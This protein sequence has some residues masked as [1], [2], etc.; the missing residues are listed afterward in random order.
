MVLG[1]TALTAQ[2]G[3]GRGPRP[4]AAGPAGNP[5]AADE[6]ARIEELVN[7]RVD[8]MKGQLSLTDKQVKDLTTVYT[9]YFNKQEKARIKHRESQ[10]KNFESK[11][12]SLAKILTPEQMQK[13]QDMPK[14]KRQM[15]APCC[16]NGHRANGKGRGPGMGPE[17]KHGP[18]F[19]PQHGPGHGPRP[20]PK[21]ST[22]PE[23]L[24]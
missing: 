19:R 18:Y 22:L 10:R 17:K 20:D 12:T 2:P 24:E 5:P 9:N 14:A 3:P 11:E 15:D 21:E 13:L 1:I 6:T 8:C 23:P 16:G 7:R 4:D